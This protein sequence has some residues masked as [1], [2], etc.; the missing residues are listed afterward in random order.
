MIGI[1]SGGKRRRKSNY[2]KIIQA[3]IQVFLDN[4]VSG[5]CFLQLPEG[6]LHLISVTHQNKEMLPASEKTACLRVP[7]V[8]KVPRHREAGVPRSVR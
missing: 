3:V 5:T 1:D 8:P 2:L 4:D 6:G 7:K